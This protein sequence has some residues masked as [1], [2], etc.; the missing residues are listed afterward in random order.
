[1]ISKYNLIRNLLLLFC[2]NHLAACNQNG[3]RG[4]KKLSA[5]DRMQHKQYV[6]NGR[7]LY[8][9]FC[10]NCHQ[11]DGSGLGQLYPPLKDADYLKADVNRTV[12]IIRYGME[13][14]IMVNGIKYDQSMPSNPKFTP[15]D[16]SEITAYIYKE[17]AD[18]TVLLK[19]NDIERLL[20]TK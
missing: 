5:A 4:F 16:I 11:K 15:L 14:E 18:T 6:A 17:F 8:L 10:S 3:D 19:P 13:G 1:M 7:V 20:L 12:R 2:L 9:R